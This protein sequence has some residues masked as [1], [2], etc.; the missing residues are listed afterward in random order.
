MFYQTFYI[1]AE[2]HKKKQ[3]Q[4]TPKQTVLVCAH[5]CVSPKDRAGPQANFPNCIDF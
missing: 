5:R 3:K 2:N 4:K 1:M